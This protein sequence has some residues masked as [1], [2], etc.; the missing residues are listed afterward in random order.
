M[1]RRRAL[2]GIG[3]TG[4]ASVAGVASYLGLDGTDREFGVDG[5]EPTV[6]APSETTVVVRAGDVDRLGITE[7]CGNSAVEF[8]LHDMHVDPKPDAAYQTL[9]PTWL[10]DANRDVTVRVPV[11]VPADADGACEYGVAAAGGDDEEVEESFTITV[12]DG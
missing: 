11:T 10:W 9:P 3:A 4:I 5:D 7:H 2:A 8:D 6:S 1:Q 12:T